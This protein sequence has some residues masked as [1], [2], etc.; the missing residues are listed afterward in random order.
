MDF[1][2]ETLWMTTNKRFLKLEYKIFCSV[3]TSRKLVT[4][5][6]R[7]LNISGGGIFHHDKI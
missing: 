2:K 6:E 7:K 3:Q 4:F 5:Q 1:Q